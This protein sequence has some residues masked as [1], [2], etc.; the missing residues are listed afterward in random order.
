MTWVLGALAVLFCGLALHPFVTYPLS[1][2]LAAAVWR[3]GGGGGG[4][5]GAEAGPV[6]ILVCAYNE[7]GVI[8]DKLRNCLALRAETPG[9]SV[10]VYTDGCSD[11]TPEVVREVGGDEVH[12]VE[13]RERRG[14]SHGMNRLARAA[15]ERG[16][17]VLF[18]TDANVAIDAGAVRAI[19]RSFADPA[20]GCVT[21]HLRYVN[22]GDSATA[23][24]GARY[25]SADEA[26]K[27]LETRT[28]SCMGADGSIF[29]IRAALFRE[30]PEGIID[31]FYTSM[32]IVCDGWRC[33]HDSGVMA[34]ERSATASG[35]E[36]RR[37]VRIA[38][39]AFNCHRLL[40][41]RLRRMGAWNR[42]KYVSHKLLRWL[43]GFSLAGAG[44][45]G[46]GA[47]L[48]APGPWGVKGGIAGAGVAGVLA[49]LWLPG[50][51]WT[52]MRQALLAVA[53]TGVG[54]VRSLQG[55]RFQTWSVA[56]T[57]RQQSAR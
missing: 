43:M 13:G 16:A 31:D 19:R 56:A 8:G 47:V 23:Q 17:E 52:T 53:A 30:V 15:L 45:A 10:F 49:V 9:T 42:Y 5:A 38:C 18:F 35:E 39:R 25:W 57:T 4:R 28:G 46:A 50:F 37:K 24:V 33:I 41:P 29:G 3:G 55:E 1:L 20:V 11:G 14:K 54:V 12:L 6:A 34:F 22:P 51:P 21:G 48:A 27:Q 2:R 26:L 40:W 44:L 7:A 36:Y 32:S